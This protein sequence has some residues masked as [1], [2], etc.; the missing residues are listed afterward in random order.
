[1]N[2][3]GVDYELPPEK[4]QILRKAERIEWIFIGFVI[5]IVIVMA[6]VMGSSQTM[7]AM[8]IEDTLS[9]V[10][11]A[12]FLVGLHFRKKLPDE[13]FPYGYR[14]AVLVG[15]MCGAITLFGFGLYI[16]G[17][18]TFKLIMAEHPTIQSTTVFGLRIWSGWLM[19]AAL[20]YSAIPP[21]ILGHIKRPLAAELHDKALHVSA[22]LNKGDWLSGIAGVAGILGIAYGLWWADA[23]AA[24]L[25]S[26]EIVKDG[27][28]NLYN[29]ITQLMNRRPSDIATHEG[30]PAIDKLQQALERLDWIDKARVRLRED[31][32]VLTGE[33]FIQLRDTCELLDRLAEARE[34]TKSVDWRLHDISLVPVRSVD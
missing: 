22:E 27:Y 1:M 2:A 3:I 23:A 9:L 15:F 32:D 34:V 31:G 10:P 6:L 14:R 29:S 17:D 4:R 7:K 19:I 16:L 30:D 33:V 13:E 18:S 26:V 12:S 21:L 28:E 25:I 11:S 8:W 24:S 20:V 5:S